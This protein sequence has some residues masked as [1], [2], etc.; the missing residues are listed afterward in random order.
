[1]PELARKFHA[2]FLKDHRDHPQVV[3]RMGI[4]EK[5]YKEKGV[6]T[7]AL[8]LS[9]ASI[10]DKIF[11]SLLLADWTAHYLADEYGID[12]ESVSTVENLKKLLNT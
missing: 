10:W 4:T 12:S 8:E 7:T 6:T 1:M 11:S 9:G 2:I 5:I 3:K